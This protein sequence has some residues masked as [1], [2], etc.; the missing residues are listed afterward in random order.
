M[1]HGN[2]DKEFKDARALIVKEIGDCKKVLAIPDL[3]DELAGYARK[4]QKEKEE[5]LYF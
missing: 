5:Q 1:A 4:L 2:L 3:C